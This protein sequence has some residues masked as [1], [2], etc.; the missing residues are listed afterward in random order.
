MVLEVA[1]SSPV[2]HPKSPL[3]R[4]FLYFSFKFLSTLFA[5]LLAVALRDW[6]LLKVYERPDAFYWSISRN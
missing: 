1:G 2:F 5:Y 3:K 6:R 4:A